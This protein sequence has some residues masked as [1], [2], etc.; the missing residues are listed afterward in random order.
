MTG[1]L[2]EVTKSPIYKGMQL[3]APLNEIR[4]IGDVI[5]SPEEQLPHRILNGTLRDNQVKE[6]K[7][8][9]LKAIDKQCLT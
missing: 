6:I 2:H 1:A 4:W 5:R 3:L 8:I 9:Q 7:I